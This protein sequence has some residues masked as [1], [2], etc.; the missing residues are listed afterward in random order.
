MLLTSFSILDCRSAS[1]ER[2]EL[3]N[4]ASIMP[5]STFI[6]SYKYIIHK[7][8]MHSM[9]SSTWL[10]SIKIS[11]TRSYLYSAIA[12]IIINILTIL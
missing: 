10:S 5:I 6:L 3:S 4:L 7:V 8:P 11:F 2:C 1:R 12:H 9:E